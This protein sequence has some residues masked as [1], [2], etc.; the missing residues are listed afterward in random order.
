MELTVRNG[1]GDVVNLNFLGGSTTNTQIIVGNG[2]NDFVNADYSSN[3]T[4]IVGNG[5]GDTV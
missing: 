1:A 2:V 4:I 3:D 5:A